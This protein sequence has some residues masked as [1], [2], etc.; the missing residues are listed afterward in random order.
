MKRG[1][2]ALLVLSIAAIGFTYAAAIVAGGTPRWSAWVIAIGASVA[3]V[4][5]MALGASRT[6]LPDAGLRRLLVPFGAVL[7]I[8]LGAFAAALLLPAAGEPLLLGLP[9]RA[10]IVLYGIGVLPA[11]ILPI[12]YA[13]TFDELTLTEEDV[14]RVRDAAGRAEGEARE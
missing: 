5:T 4:A 12:T 7:L 10:A 8:M 13:L 1:A 9:R 6:G 2:L 14:Q 11:L 3:M